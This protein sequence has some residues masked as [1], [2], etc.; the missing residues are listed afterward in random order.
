[1]VF[2]GPLEDTNS[3]VIHAFVGWVG[4]VVLGPFEG[5]EHA[6]WKTRVYFREEDG[7]GEGGVGVDV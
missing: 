5:C 2:G 3:D 6:F 7:E 4:S 1:M